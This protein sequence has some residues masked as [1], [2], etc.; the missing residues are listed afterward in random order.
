MDSPL[1]SGGK[2]RQ[3]IAV[4]SLSKQLIQKLEW[5]ISFWNF[6]LWSDISHSVGV[7]KLTKS[8]PIRTKHLSHSIVL[9]VVLLTILYKSV[10]NLFP[11][12]PLLGSSR[13]TSPEA[14]RD[15][16]SSVL[17]LHHDPNDLE[18]IHLKKGKSVFGLKNPILDFPKKSTRAWRKQGHA[19]ILSADQGEEPNEQLQSRWSCLFSLCTRR[20][21]H[22]IDSTSCG[23]ELGLKISSIYLANNLALNNLLTGNQKPWFT[24]W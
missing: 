4:K 7:L 17:L 13:N 12:Q 23:R 18:L 15:D 14:L 19:V 6:K 2:C 10:S 9:N 22:D 24:L 1:F 8:E 11:S 3:V 20:A 16:V 5:R 21:K